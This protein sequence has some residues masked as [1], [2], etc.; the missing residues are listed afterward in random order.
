MC[1]GC[2]LME[3]LAAKPR[4]LIDYAQ[5]TWSLHLVK[6][7]LNLQSLTKRNLDCKRTCWR[8]IKASWQHSRT[9]SSWHWTNLQRWPS[10]KKQILH[11]STDIWLLAISS[12]LL[13]LRNSALKL[14]TLSNC[15]IYFMIHSAQMLKRVYLLNFN[16]QTCINGLKWRDK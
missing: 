6:A 5:T 14:P 16:L 11:V 4:Y 3:R 15:F 2:L 7:F 8:K 10:Q 12:K 1:L 13:F 9:S